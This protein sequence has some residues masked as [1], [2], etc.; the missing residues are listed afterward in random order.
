LG[1]VVVEPIVRP[2]VFFRDF[3]GYGKDGSFGLQPCI[4]IRGCLAFEVAQREC[5][6]TD[7]ANSRRLPGRPKFREDRVDA[8]DEIFA[9]ELFAGN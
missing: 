6:T 7:D 4:N 3:C 8:T 9:F 5:R 2:T 1:R